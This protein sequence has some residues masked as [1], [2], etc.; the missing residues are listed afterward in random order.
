MKE[1]HVLLENAF[2]NWHR[3]ERMYRKA[4]LQSLFDTISRSVISCLDVYYKILKE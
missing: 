2:R 4:N 1:T 3:N